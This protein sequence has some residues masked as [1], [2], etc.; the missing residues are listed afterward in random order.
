[1]RKQ[2]EKICV[3]ILSPNET[4]R[5]GCAAASQLNSDRRN[6]RWKTEM[7]AGRGRAYWRPSATAKSTGS[8]A[9]ELQSQL[10]L[11]VF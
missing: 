7:R 1:M 8:N 11:P 3:V 2:K 10:P 5:A 6:S 4:R 9:V